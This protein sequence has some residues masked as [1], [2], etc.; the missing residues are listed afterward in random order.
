MFTFSVTTGAV[1]LLT[2]E[3][4]FVSPADGLPSGV[5]VVDVAVTTVA[6]KAELVG[7]VVLLL[8][9]AASGVGGLADTSAPLIVLVG[10]AAT[11]AVY[12][13]GSLLTSA[14]NAT[15]GSVTIDFGYS[16]LAG[17]SVVSLAGF[18]GVLT[19]AALLSYFTYYYLDF[20]IF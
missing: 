20:D 19:A 5:L 9:L 17:A 11:A 13:V 8:V 2:E 10:L 15:D 12:F 3:F 1:V 16:F 14:F 6:F 7:E 18:S 4:T